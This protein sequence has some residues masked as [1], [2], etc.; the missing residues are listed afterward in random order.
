MPAIFVLES[1]VVHNLFLDIEHYMSCHNRST[2]VFIYQSSVV[3]H[4]FSLLSV[5]VV[6]VH[7][8]RCPSSSSVVVRR[9]HCPPSLSLSVVVVRRRPS[10]FV[11]RHPSSV[12]RCPS[13]G[14]P[15]VVRPCSFCFWSSPVVRRP[16]QSVRYICC[17]RGGC[18]CSLHFLA[19][20]TD[21]LNVGCYC[22][23]AQEREVERERET[24]QRIH[25]NTCLSVHLNLISACG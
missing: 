16:S 11:V 6:V 3:R 22:F 7:R 10:S 21:D 13:V 18:I 19:P 8:R 4:P 1:I 23:P 9:R 12:V 20:A 24:P 15:P 17:I 14:R 2:L 5:I 25:E